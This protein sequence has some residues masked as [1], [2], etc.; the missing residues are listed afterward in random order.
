M[1]KYDNYYRIIQ[2][3]I[4][5][6]LF[7]TIVTFMPWTL[8][9]FLKS[10][11][12]NGI[13]YVLLFSIIGPVLTVIIHE[14]LKFYETDELEVWRKFSIK[15]MFKRYIDEFKESFILSL[16]SNILIFIWLVD[17]YY[18]TKINSNF[19]IFRFI[20]LFFIIVSLLLQF[21]MLMITAQFKFKFKDKFKMIFGYLFLKPKVTIINLT[22]I[23]LVAIFMI[24]ISNFVLIL[25]LPQLLILLVNNS[26]IIVDDIYE[27]FILEDDKEVV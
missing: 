3:N 27:N 2:F 14:I 15:N 22:T 8:I 23:L 1:N 7:Y 17:I 21:Y 26:L 13:F 25:F 20:F 12:S 10:D 19:S 6:W 11:L 24:L 4:K 5:I 9:L 18:V 16:I